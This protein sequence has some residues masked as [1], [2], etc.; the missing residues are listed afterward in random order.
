ML[1]KLV[2]SK[3]L[4]SLTKIRKNWD[5]DRKEN[6]TQVPYEID[7][8]LKMAIER[9]IREG[10]VNCN[11]RD[12]EILTSKTIDYLASK[13]LIIK[14][15]YGGHMFPL[16]AGVELPTKE[17]FIKQTKAHLDTFFGKP[18]DFTDE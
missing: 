9:Q 17:A 1:P 16:P 15:P 2:Y 11:K 14:S 12:M 13:G 18:K 4:Q 6:P 7:S 5:E 3:V 8:E 10:K